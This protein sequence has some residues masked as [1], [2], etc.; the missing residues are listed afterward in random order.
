MQKNQKTPA[1]IGR[2]ETVTP[3]ALALLTAGEE[4]VP[5]ETEPEAGNVMKTRHDTIKNSIGNIR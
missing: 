5:V 1:A 2:F 4:T 3:A